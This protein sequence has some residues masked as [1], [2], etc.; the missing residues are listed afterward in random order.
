MKRTPFR[1]VGR[2]PSHDTVTV[3]AELLAEAKAG[4]VLGMA[5]VAMYQAREYEVGYTGECAR[6]PTFTSGMLLDLVHQI[7]ASTI[8]AATRPRGPQR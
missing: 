4:R 1:L 7:S 2:K 5:F 6:S 3:L 8:E